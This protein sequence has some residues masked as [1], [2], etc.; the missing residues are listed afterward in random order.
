M[1]NLTFTLLLMILPLI[2]ML[3]ACSDDSTRADTQDPS[4]TEIASINAQFSTLTGALQSAGLDAVLD[5]DGE[6]TVF[7]PTNDAFSA[8]P[9][10][11]LESLS[12]EQLEAVLLYHVLGTGVLSGQLGAQ[13]AVTSLQGG[14][15]FITAGNDGVFVNG[16][17]SVTSADIEARNGVIHAIDAVI[18][19][20]AFGNIVD[21]ASKRYFLSALVDA[22]VA[23]D[24][25]GALTADGPFTVFAPTNDAFNAIES[26]AAGLTAQ[27]LANIL[28]YHVVQGEVL[29]GDLQPTQQVPSLNGNPLTIEVSGGTATINGS[30]TVTT[31]DIQGTNG[32]IHVIDQV[33]LPP[34]Q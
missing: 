6:F 21:N 22:V 17:A 3:S 34:A 12:N 10:G 24:L 1:R 4:I 11:T 33:L 9:A 32:V 31:V 30:S 23:A 18:L 15:I 20:D 8:L 5:G 16:S 13:Q 14:D 27:E 19:P 26:V 29:S 2:L 28:L 25:A 7:A